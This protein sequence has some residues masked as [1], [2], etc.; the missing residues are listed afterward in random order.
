MGN[1]GTMKIRILMT[2]IALFLVSASSPSADCYADYRAKSENPF[3]L[4]YGVIQIPDHLC[5]QDEAARYI[6][7]R[8]STEGWV[9]LVVDSLFGVNGLKQRSE[10]AGQYLLRY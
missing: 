8:I 6:A 4:H 7:E 1:Q 3:R 9:L 2:A 10:D 5:S